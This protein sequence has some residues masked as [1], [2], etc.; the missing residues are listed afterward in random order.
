MKADAPLVDV[1]D[2]SIAFSQ[3][4]ERRTVVDRASFRLEKGKALALVGKSG[5]GKTVTAQAIV[6]L[7]PQPA[8]S[9]PTGEILFVAATCWRCRTANCAKC[10]ARGNDG[11]PGADGGRSTRC[12]RVGRQIG[13]SSSCMAS[14]QARWRRAARIVGLLRR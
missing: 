12:T 10:G 4:A 14:I 2:L 5:S 6:R 13:E 7:L 11:V 9:Y 8:A 3:G 1:R